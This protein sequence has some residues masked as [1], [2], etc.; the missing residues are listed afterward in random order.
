MSDPEKIEALLA[1]AQHL[2]EELQRF[3]RLVDTACR[4]QIGSQK[5]IERTAKAIQEATA[6]VSHIDARAQALTR[7]LQRAQMAQQ[8]PI[9]RLRARAE[10]LR[11]RHE[12]H[13]ALKA[14]FAELTAEAASLAQ[15]TQ[16][17]AETSSIQ[18]DVATPIA[19][20]KDRLKVARENARSLMQD[21]HSMRF[22]EV[23]K[24]V[25]RFEQML[26][27]L[28]RKIVQTEE[29]LTAARARVQS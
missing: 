25:H 18:L 4:G 20:L 24:D 6:V 21:A 9:D 11:Q 22:E 10:L 15:I 5:D 1:A 13:E 29:S 2:E 3:G 28:E 27:T 7:S 26:G 16:P 14:R 17:L 8:G 12:E 19:T 23:A